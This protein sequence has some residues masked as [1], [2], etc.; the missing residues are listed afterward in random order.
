MTPD[1]VGKISIQ[2]LLA[3]VCDELFVLSDRLRDVEKVLFD[4]AQSVDLTSH[5]AQMQDMDLI[6]QQISDL[7]RAIHCVTEVELDG[8]QVITSVLGDRLHLNDLR[9]RLLGLSEDRLLRAPAANTDVLL[10]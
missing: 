10:F 9:Q 7:A 4:D 3:N 2:E 8:A 5:V 6:I 1:V